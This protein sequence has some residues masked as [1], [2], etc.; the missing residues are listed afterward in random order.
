MFAGETVT[1]IAVDGGSTPARRARRSRACSA[2]RS[3]NQVTR[4]KA[5]C[6][7][8]AARQAGGMT[9]PS[10]TTG[11]GGPDAPTMA[12]VPGTTNAAALSGV[13]PTAK[14][15]LARKTMDARATCR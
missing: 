12:D 3:A 10:A 11:A 4:E 1:E 8:L 2:T 14:S 6:A 9:G 13:A 15:T 7:G 5:Q